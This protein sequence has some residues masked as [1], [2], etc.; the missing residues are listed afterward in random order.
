MPQLRDLKLIANGSDYLFPAR[1][2]SSRGYI[3]DD[4]TNHTLATLF[5]K[6]VS[7]KPPGPNFLGLADIEYFTVH[8]LRRTNELIETGADI[9]VFKR[10]ENS[11]DL[12][13]WYN[14]N[15]EG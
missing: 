15:S 14:C 5:G 6:S 13:P 12:T 10:R 8:D 11:I 9:G 4:T 7:K 1:K 2:K 3:S